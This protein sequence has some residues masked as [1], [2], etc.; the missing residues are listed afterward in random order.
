VVVVADII[1]EGEAEGIEYFVN[2]GRRVGTV[3]GVVV[4]VSIGYLVFNTT[5]SSSS[6]V[7]SAVVV[8]SIRL[9]LL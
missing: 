8:S 7:V 1:S 3:F 6:L 2:I 5:G 4:G 9:V